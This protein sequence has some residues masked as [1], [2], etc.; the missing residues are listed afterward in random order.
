MSASFLDLPELFSQPFQR[1]FE[2]LEPILQVVI[3]LDR[4]DLLHRAG[5]QCAHNKRAEPTEKALHGRKL[6]LLLG[7]VLLKRAQCPGH[8]SGTCVATAAWLAGIAA[9]TCFGTGPTSLA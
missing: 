6:A 8:N 7:E 9:S 2:V 5:A 1:L 3:A 4:V